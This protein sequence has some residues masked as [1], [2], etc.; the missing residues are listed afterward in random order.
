[1]RRCQAVVLSGPMFIIRWPHL[2]L[3]HLPSHPGRHQIALPPA[4]RIY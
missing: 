3:Q 4:S 2:L 1:M